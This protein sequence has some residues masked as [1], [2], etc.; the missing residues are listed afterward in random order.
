MIY[1]VLMQGPDGQLINL[2]LMALARASSDDKTEIWF[3]S[4]EYP[5]RVE[6]PFQT[7]LDRVAGILDAD[8]ER[9][10]P[11]TRIFDKDLPF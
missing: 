4:D 10:I 5:I 7:F 9:Y 8:F 6:M 1:P 2:S 3:R 11:P